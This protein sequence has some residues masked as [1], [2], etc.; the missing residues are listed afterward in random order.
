MTLEETT[1]KA[2]VLVRWRIERFRLR[3]SGDLVLWFID[4]YPVPTG[5]TLAAIYHVLDPFFP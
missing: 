2:A 5:T 3:S 1:Q 4:T